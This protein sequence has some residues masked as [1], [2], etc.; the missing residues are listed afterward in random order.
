[1]TFH[2]ALMFSP[3]SCLLRMSHRHTQ[4]AST[5]ALLVMVLVISVWGMSTPTE[6]AT[7]EEHLLTGQ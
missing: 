6:G 1:M 5:V 7:G 2:S 4:A 3:L